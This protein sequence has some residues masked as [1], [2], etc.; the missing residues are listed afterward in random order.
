MK[1]IGKISGP[2][3]SRNAEAISLNFDMWSNG[4]K[5]INLV[6][7]VLVASFGDVEGWI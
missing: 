2:K 3:I 6:E 7:I 5:Y 1:K 4:R